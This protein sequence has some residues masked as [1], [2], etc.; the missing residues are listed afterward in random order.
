[1]IGK[2]LNL[3]L[4]FYIPKSVTSHHDVSVSVGDFIFRYLRIT[5]DEL[6]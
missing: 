1:L 5:D 2:F 3:V 4:A 6:L